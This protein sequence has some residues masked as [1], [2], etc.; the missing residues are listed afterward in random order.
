MAR[1]LLT[2]P[3]AEQTLA[4][5]FE[6]IRDELGLPD[7]FPPDV[8]DAAEA[9]RSRGPLP[10]DR[11]DQSALPFATLDPRESRDL[12][13]AFHIERA[14]AALVLR[15]AIADVA[16]WVQHG[17]AL[18]A[19]AWRRAVTVYSPDLRTP[20]YPPGLSEGAASL[21]PGDARPAVVFTIEVSGEGDAEL[22]S[23]RRALVRSVA[24]LAY[25]DAERDPPPLLIDMATRLAAAEARRGAVRIEVPDQSIVRDEVAPGGFRLEPERRLVSEDWNAQLSLVTNLLVAR[26]QL[27]A[28]IGLMRVMPPTDPAREAGLRRAAAALGMPTGDDESLG[29]IL[30]RLDS[31][32]PHHV[33]FMVS[34][35]RALGRARYA[36]LPVVDGVV[37]HAAIAAPYAHATAPLRRLG[38]RYV[39]EAALA[40]AAGEPVPEAVVAAFPRLP[41]VLARGDSLAGRLDAA[42]VDLV[43]AHALRGMVGQRLRAVVTAIDDRGAMLQVDDPPVRSRA[44]VPAGVKPGDVLEVVLREADPARRLVRLEIA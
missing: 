35:R 40:V 38:D 12:D 5:G 43:E 2:R 8:L 13:Q 28:G 15:Y 1:R 44:T 23:V 10:A 25:E 36:A 22:R 16:A 19:E 4:A 31:T 37:E 30:R 3:D 33:A 6:A 39:L 42:C 20:L 41:P 14:G 29:A 9:A 21:L 11:D 34:A 18:D 7:E 17:D 27:A 24:K 32:D 26:A